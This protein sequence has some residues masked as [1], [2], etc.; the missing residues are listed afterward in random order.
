MA[1]NR[2]GTELQSGAMVKPEPDLFLFVQ[3]PV[4][5]SRLTSS[6]IYQKFQIFG[7]VFRER[8]E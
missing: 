4:I 1:V 6:A 2:Y 5:P 8:T 3:R 7:M